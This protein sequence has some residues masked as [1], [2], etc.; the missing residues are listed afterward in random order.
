M[1]ATTEDKS[2]MVITTM[3][4]TRRTIVMVTVLSPPHT[5]GLNYEMLMMSTTMTTTTTTGT[6]TTTTT[7]TRLT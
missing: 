2:I 5:P 3:T 6:T 1:T 7:T 4:K